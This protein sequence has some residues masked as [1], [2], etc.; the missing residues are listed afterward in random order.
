M[1]VA[2][3][4]SSTILPALGHAAMNT[5]SFPAL[6]SLK[7]DARAVG[8]IL[9]P[10]APLKT[11]RLEFENGLELPL[12]V[13]VIV[14][15]ALPRSAGAQVDEFR[16]NAN[17]WKMVRALAG[18]K[19]S[20]KKQLAATAGDKVYLRQHGGVDELERE[21]VV[22]VIAGGYELSDLGNAI[23]AEEGEES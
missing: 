20:T 22:T 10:V 23:L 18:G 16:P 13:G 1:A 11:V 21:G 6:E 12:A 3:G 2:N 5:S 4:I 14:E 15:T 17:Q 7:L 19:K 9:C 8:A